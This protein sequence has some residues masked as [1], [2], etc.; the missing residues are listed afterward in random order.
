MKEGN[1]IKKITVK[2][3]VTYVKL[4]KLFGKLRW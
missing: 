4:E 3:Y 2:V 1:Y